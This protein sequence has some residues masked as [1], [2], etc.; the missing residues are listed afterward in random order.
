MS[1]HDSAK[2]PSTTDASARTPSQPEVSPWPV[3]ARSVLQRAQAD[4]GSVTHQDVQAL[5]RTIGNRAAT[6]LLQ[7]RLPLG[8]AGDRVQTKRSFSPLS[9][10]RDR[11]PVSTQISPSA[12]GIQRYVNKDAAGDAPLF[13]KATPIPDDQVGPVPAVVTKKGVNQTNLGHYLERHTYKY[14]KLNAKTISPAATLFPH[15]TTADDVKS[16]LVEAMGKVKDSDAIGASPVSLAVD[17]SNGIKVNLGA[18]KNNKLAAFFPLSG[19]GVVNYTPDEL[20]AI[21]NEKN[22]PPAT[23]GPA[24]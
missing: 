8:P 6:R 17:L 22:K 9:V 3:D 13:E 20:K 14:Q 12:N 5:Q 16:Y 23:K 15:G 18:L 11:P 2:D 1:R 24:K 19:P 4:P 7:T 21:R 10:G